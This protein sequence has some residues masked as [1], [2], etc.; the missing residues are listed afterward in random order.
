MDP[1]NSKREFG[2]FLGYGS[3]FTYPAYRAIVQEAERLGYSAVWVQD[4]I[5]GHHPIPRDIEI[6][7]TWTFLTALAANTSAIRVG[8]MATPALRRFAPLL[9]KTTASLDVIS[10]GRVNIGLGSGDDAYQ[11]EMIG[12]RFPESGKE[13]RQI[14]RESIEVMRLLWTEDMANFNGE[15]L[16]LR[17]AIMSPKPV[18]KPGPPIYIACNTSRRLM[19]RMAATYGDGLGIMWGHDPTVAQTVQVFQE[20]W[21]AAGRDPAAYKALRSTFIIF[22]N[23]SDEEKARQYASRVTTF[24]FDIR[25]TASPAKVP[26]GSDADMLVIGSPA[27]VAEELERRVFDIGFNQLMTT[28][29][30]CE[31]M[32]PET[33]G[34]K[35]W[36]GSYLAGLRLLADQVLPSL[37]RA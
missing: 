35:G 13:R 24:P 14:L 10:G 19:P 20:E 17:D 16:Q 29:V 9:A 6:L 1:V 22:T 12:Q 18:Q 33:D 15:H 25:Q 36:A 4:N 34:L 8:S 11:Y 21:A 32:K 30:V 23:D 26:E 31:D 27:H 2:L 5:T 37:R 7:D 28:F 3:G